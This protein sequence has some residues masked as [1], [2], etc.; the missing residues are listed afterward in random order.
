MCAVSAA[1]LLTMAV[2]AGAKPPPPVNGTGTLH[3]Q[4]TAKLSFSPALKA[5]GTATTETVT[6]KSVLHNCTGTVDGARVSN[7]K[8][9]TTTVD[10]TNDCT[11]VLTGAGGGT[12]P[13]GQIAWK[14]SNPK[15]NP[16]TA[17]TLGAS[18]TN[19]GPPI[20]VDTTGGSI[21]GGSFAG[22]TVATH[23]VI[24][25][26]LAFIQKKCTTHGLKAL[27]INPSGSTF[28]LS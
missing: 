18:T 15:L 13:P 19:N 21:G 7:G 4:V 9:T 17:V 22:D 16:S 27:H 20:T 2:P 10:T 24:S 26:S 28:T 25:E 14:S 8:S 6:L 12:T 3:C 11:K 5:N 1:V 23:S